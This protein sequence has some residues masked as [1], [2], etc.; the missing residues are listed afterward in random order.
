[1]S[2]LRKHSKF[3][4]D[5]GFNIDITHRCGLECPLCQRQTY[6]NARGL[7]IPG[8]DI[9]LDEFRK[10]AKY[11]NEIS[12]CGQLS[13]PIHH[14]KFIEI[15]KICK[16]YN[17]ATTVHNASSFKNKNWYIDAFKANPDAYWWF[18]IDGLPEESHI[19]RVNQDGVKLFEV[20]L[21]AKQ[22]LNTTPLWQYIVFQYNQD[23][24]EEAKTMAK[25]NGVDFLL[26]TSS[27]WRSNNDPLRPTID[28]Y[29]MSAK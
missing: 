6:W 28:E 10:I 19:Y 4:K 26:V 20:M 18:A 24:I 15:L 9:P 12:F 13:D 7:R 16:E 22:H 5:R 1:M 23:H 8:E 14:P 17:V 3:R 27:R 21:K 11:T 25:D 29:R 2:K